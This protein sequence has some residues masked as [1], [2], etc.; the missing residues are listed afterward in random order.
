MKIKNLVFP[1]RLQLV[2]ILLL[3][4][5]L[6][7]AVVVPVLALG[8][9]DFYLT[10]NT[11]KDIH[12]NVINTPGFTSYTMLKQ[13]PPATPSLPASSVSI[14]SGTPLLWLADQAAQENVTFHSGI[15]VMLLKVD[16]AWDN[17]TISAVIGE[18]DTHTNTFNPFSTSTALN[19]SITNGG[20][21]NVIRWEFQA[22]DTTIYKGNYLALK[23]TN[24]DALAGHTIYTDGQSSL[25]SPNSDPG[26][27][28]PEIAA[29][30]LLGGGI[31]AT[32]GFMAFKRRKIAAVAKI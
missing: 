17:G 6:L 5:I 12:G 11:P 3:V 16:S 4:G 27:P 21:E 30:L 7:M 18:W 22:S 31:V 20:I 32:L 8:V 14:P 1:N 19:K 13:N 15:W 2:S 28:L 10:N 26:Y 23:I 29:G 25:K 24:N 9:Q